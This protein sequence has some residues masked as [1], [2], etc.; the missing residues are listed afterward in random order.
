[1]MTKL[2][3]KN[4][5]GLSVAFRDALDI[6]DRALFEMNQTKGWAARSARS[7]EYAEDLRRCYTTF[8]HSPLFCILNGE[9]KVYCTRSARWLHWQTW[10]KKHCAGVIPEGFLN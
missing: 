8:H 9:L 4:R 2:K 7:A 1:M 6:F 10:V 5:E 3:N